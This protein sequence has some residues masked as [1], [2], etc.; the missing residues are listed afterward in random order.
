MCGRIW[1][2]LGERGEGLWWIN[3]SDG[4]ERGPYPSGP[5]ARMAAEGYEPAGDGQYRLSE[6]P[7]AEA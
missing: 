6:A 4:S 5:D 3:Y 2:T 7:D 1:P